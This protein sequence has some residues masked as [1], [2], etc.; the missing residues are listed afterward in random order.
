MPA[1]NFKL[2][3]L[4]AADGTTATMAE[5]AGSI[6]A[7]TIVQFQ[8]IMDKLVEKGVKNLILD[9][10]SV[11]YI[12]STGL[13]TLL[14]YV[15][16]FESMDG[17]IGF[18]R[19]PSKVMLVMEMLGFN[20]LF[21]IVPDEAAAL[22]YFGGKPLAAPAAAVPSAAPA[23]PTISPAVQPAR[24]AA[25]AISPAAPTI[26]PAAPQPAVAPA[27]AAPA[28]PSFPLAVD[29]ARCRAAVEVSGPG[30]FRCPRCES[31]LTVG[32]DGRV[33]FFAPK[34][35]RPVQVSIPARP[36]LVEAL[37]PLVE[38]AARQ[39]GLDDEAADQVGAAVVT[40]SKGVA[41]L[42]YEGDPLGALH[43]ILAPDAN[44]LTVMISD[45]G[46]TISLGPGGPAEDAR[47]AGVASRMDSVNIRPN[48]KGG[49][50]LTLTKRAGSRNV[51]RKAS[52]GRS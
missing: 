5:I 19:V 25:P 3:N 37:K 50:L 30:K 23:A 27:P 48:P 49:N 14:K 34:K 43:I 40:A 42:A 39:I 38:G 46:K 51:A 7:T 8:N 15:D 33:R 13:G 28:M 2:K 10:S 21:T 4:K 6:D 52:R 20:A 17:H 45:F 16:T 29:C 31:V 41:S 18:T 12:N 22:R 32:D 9:C 24:G 35:A 44:S 36:E 1:L 11:K 26:S 47:F